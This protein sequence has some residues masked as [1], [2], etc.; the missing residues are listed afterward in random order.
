MRKSGKLQIV[1]GI[2]LLL[3]L[4]ISI[5]YAAEEAQKPR[6]VRGPR[7]RGGNVPDKKTI[8]P[9]APVPQDDAEK[10]ILNILADMRK[11]QSR[12]M[13]NVPR[14]D[15]RLLRLLTEMS[16]AKNVVEI[17][18]SNGYS[19][20][21]ICLALRK[22]GGKLTTFEYNEGR[23]KLARENFKRAGVEKLVTLVPGDAHKNVPKL[24]DPID[25]LFLDA[26]KAGYVD[27][28]NKL[29]PLIRAG[30]LIIAH[31][32][33][34]RQADAKFLEAI[35]T[36]PNLETVLVNRYLAGI[37]MTMKKR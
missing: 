1:L 32:I 17:G 11:N 7:R 9:Q 25:I 27:Y 12:G 30:G 13:M 29:L 4:M 14:E 34:P 35:N 6:Q 18:T 23:A 33:N 22:T 2:V 19:G 16:D 36:N 3:T 31:N 24:K 5:L 21:W 37:S 10:K 26:D 8:E 15:G 20:I 28:L